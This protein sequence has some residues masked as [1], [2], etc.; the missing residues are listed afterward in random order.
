MYTVTVTRSF[1]AQHF[2]TVPDPGPEGERHSHT[3][4]VEARLAGPELDEDG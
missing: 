4:D 2:L 3:F 1:V